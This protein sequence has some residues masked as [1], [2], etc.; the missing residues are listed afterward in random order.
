MIFNLFRSLRQ[1][2]DLE[3]IRRYQKQGNVRYVA[4]LFKRYS[5]LISGLCLKYL[6]HPEDAEDAAMDIFEILCKDLK[7][8][9]VQK[10]DNWLYSVTRYHCLKVIKRRQKTGYATEI[11]DDFMENGDDHSLQ[12]KEE[13]EKLLSTMHDSLSNLKEDQRVCIEMF[14]LKKMSYAEI[15]SA[16]GHD[17]KKVK[18]HIQNGKRKLKI[19]IDKQLEAES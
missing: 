12:E 8:H 11:S 1:L 16:T 5:Q 14:Y 7:T 13:L 18:S 17:L 6:K 3:L 9:D 19:L 4:A 10:V 15:S 2:D